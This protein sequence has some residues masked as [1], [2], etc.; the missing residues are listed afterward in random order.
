VILPVGISFYTFQALSY[1]ID[2]YRGQMRA[3]RDFVGF[4]AFV[5]LFPQLVAGPIERASHLLP[6]VESPRRFNW[7][8]TR[9]GVLL[10]TW[11]YF[12]K[13]VIADNVGI[14]ANKI[15]SLEEAGFAVLWAGVF[16]FAIQIY[17]DFSAYTDIARGVARCF[18][19]SLMRNFRHP[20]LATGPADFWHRWH[21]SLSTWFRDYVFIPLGG[22][23]GGT[24]R[25]ARNIMITFVVSGLWHGASW[26]FVLW[27]TYHGVL[28]VVSRLM[29]KV[30]LAPALSAALVPFRVVGMF[31]LTL[32]GWLMFR[33][34][35]PAIQWRGLT[36]SPF[37]QS[38]AE[39]QQGG[40]L[41][42]LAAV[43]SLAVWVDSVWSEWVQ[44]V[45]ARRRS[46]DAPASLGAFVGRAALAGLAVAII[47]VL[48]SRQSL[49]FI[50]FQF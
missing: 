26:N 18:G 32:V 21:I 4:A 7:M 46:A 25:T 47:L 28:V 30:T 20:Y 23:R 3:R 50:Y 37:G 19:F 14:I 22:S 36:L 11:G 13:L 41:F 48:R 15:F 44:P 40:Y 6:Q 45:L 49:D 34:S 10:A 42:L 39:W 16:A 2:V 35:D 31:G 27:G 12:K 1:T 33:E 9:D 43:Y 5:A 24:W 29:P 17:A 38:A 8:A